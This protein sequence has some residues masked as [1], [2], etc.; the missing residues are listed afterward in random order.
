MKL[1]YLAGR[2]WLASFFRSTSGSSSFVASV[3]DHAGATTLVQSILVRFSSSRD[4]Y[5]NDELLGTPESGEKIHS[6]SD[7]ALRQ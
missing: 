5:E 6:G 1:A 4:E 7:A 2:D 3:G